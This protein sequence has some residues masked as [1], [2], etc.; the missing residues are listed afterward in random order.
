M[1]AKKQKTYTLLE[2]DDEVGDAGGAGGSGSVSISIG[3]Q[4]QKQ[5]NRRKKFRK[6]TEILEDEDD[7]A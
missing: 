2:A 3:T 4:S 6:R 5:E 1:L 7:E